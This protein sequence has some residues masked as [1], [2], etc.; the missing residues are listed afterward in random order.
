MTMHRSFIISEEEKNRILNFHKNATKNSYLILKEQNSEPKTEEEWKKVY[1]CVVNYLD[2]EGKSISTYNP[3]DNTYTVGDFIYYSNGEKEYFGMAV[4]NNPNRQPGKR[5]FSCSDEEFSPQNVGVE[6]DVVDVVSD[7][8]G[9]KIPQD[10]DAV[11]PTTTT[12]TTTIPPTT[13]TTTTVKPKLPVLA[14]EK[15]REYIKKLENALSLKVK[16][17]AKET[18]KMEKRA[19]GGNYE[20]K[21]W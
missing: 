3:S 9:P 8:S 20:I 11:A 4:P 21:P 12:T 15:T 2:K 10:Y 6:L 7:K 17:K 19:Q 16:G 13:T 14:D 5:K 18:E 1:P